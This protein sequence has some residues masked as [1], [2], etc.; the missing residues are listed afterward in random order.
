MNHIYIK[1][2]VE[3]IKLNIISYDGNEHRKIKSDELI[4]PVSFNMGDKL[5]YI[6]KLISIIIEQYNIESYN[7][8]VDNNIGVEI[9]DAVKIEGVLEELFSCKG[10]EIWR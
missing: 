2:F 10:V 6:K 7:I 5:Y 9:I 8:E 3:K 1:I 4:L